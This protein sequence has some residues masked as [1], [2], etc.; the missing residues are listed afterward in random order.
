MT[1]C[2]G[3]RRVHARQRIPCKRRVVELRIQ[4]V[5]RRVAY[6]AVT[7]KIS[8]RVRRIAGPCEVCL[9]ATEAI[10]RR[11]L[12]PVTRV[13]SY[14]LQRGVHSSQRITRHGEV[15]E[16]RPKPVIHRVARIALH[17][18]ARVVDRRI[19]RILRV[20]CIASGRQPREPPHRRA[21][22]AIGAFHHR[23]GTH[24]WKTVGMV[25]YV[26]RRNLPSLH[27][28]A[29]LAV[30]AELPHVNIRMAIRTVRAY[31]L[32]HHRQVALRAANIPVHAF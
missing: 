12:E 1:L 29:L 16:L 32:E 18:K 9:V 3:Q 31:V 4:P 6:P 27:R 5:A 20:A 7:G 28:M 22:V 23:M 25:L 14:A 30:R 13:A 17:R 11:A 8:L 19:L 26:A 2:A 15:I 10:G 21:L 24:Q